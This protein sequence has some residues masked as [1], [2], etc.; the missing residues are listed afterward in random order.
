MTNFKTTTQLAS[1]GSY[2]KIAFSREQHWPISANSGK[3]NRFV[4]DFRGLAVMRRSKTFMFCTPDLSRG[5]KDG[6]PEE[7]MGKVTRGD[8]HIKGSGMLVVSLRGVNQ[9]RILV[10]LRVHVLDKT[11]FYLALKFSYIAGFHCHAIKIKIKN[12]SMNEVKKLT[13]YRQ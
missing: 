3:R 11:P 5:F 1:Q 6:N 7:I 13:C 10:S 8:S 9:F 12:H 4:F 2:W